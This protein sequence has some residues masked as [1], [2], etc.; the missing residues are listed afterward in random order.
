MGSC[1]FLSGVEEDARDLDDRVADCQSRGEARFEVDDGR[2][3]GTCDSSGGREGGRWFKIS[4]SE[5]VGIRWA[6]SCSNESCGVTCG[7]K[8]RTPVMELTL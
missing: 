5:G 7:L 8:V 6:D 1:G 2:S 3:S 4:S